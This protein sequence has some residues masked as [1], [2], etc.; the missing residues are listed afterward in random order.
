MFRSSLARDLTVLTSLKLVALTVLYFVSF[1]P[2]HRPTIDPVAHFAGVSSPSS[3][4]KP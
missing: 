2:A 4:Q 1:S 3:P